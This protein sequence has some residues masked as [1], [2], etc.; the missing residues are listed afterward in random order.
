MKQ[1]IGVLAISYPR[2]HPRPPGDNEYKCLDAPTHA[3][4]QG[5]SNLAWAIYGISDIV[6]V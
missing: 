3:V 4:V 6:H 5:D 2:N 1:Q